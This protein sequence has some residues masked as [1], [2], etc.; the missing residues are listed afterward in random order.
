MLISELVVLVEFVEFVEFVILSKISSK[1]RE[2]VIIS[3]ANYS[4]S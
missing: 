4:N 2:V 3:S 1:I